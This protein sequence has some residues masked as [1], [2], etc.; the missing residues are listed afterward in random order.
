MA[1]VEAAP[2]VWEICKKKKKRLGVFLF[3]L[4]YRRLQREKEAFF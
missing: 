1:A 2:N 4:T 3:R